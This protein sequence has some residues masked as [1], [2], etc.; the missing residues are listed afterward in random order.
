MIELLTI[1]HALRFS[2][3]TVVPLFVMWNVIILL[4]LI[5]A[6]IRL[7]RKEKFCERSKRTTA[8]VSKL[9]KI[10]SSDDPPSFYSSYIFHDENGEAFTGSFSIE[11]E[12]DHC[13]G[14]SVTVFYDSNNPM[15][16][17]CVKQLASDRRMIRKIPKMVFS[18][19]LF[20]MVLILIVFISQAIF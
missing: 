13:E 16:H 11:S 1:S 12:E 2:F 5:F 7:R 6:T 8:R 18:G 19:D 20:F 14:Q 10:D 15:N 3:V 9:I 4:I 17:V